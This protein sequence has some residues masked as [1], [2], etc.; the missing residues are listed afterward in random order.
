MRLVAKRTVYHLGPE[1]AAVKKEL[2]RRRRRDEAN[3]ASGKSRRELLKEQVEQSGRELYPDPPTVDL[4]LEI[5]NRSQHPVELWSSGDPV[6]LDLEMRGP[7]VITIN[8]GHF[9]TMEFRIPQ[10]TK[11]DPGEVYRRPI[12]RLAHGTRGDGKWDY[13]TSPGRYTLTASFRTGIRPA[14]AGM[15]VEQDE[16]MAG[17]AVVVLVAPPITVDVTAMR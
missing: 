13:W 8:P 4:V 9:H 12:R 14:P 5:T 16:D 10:A 3:A 2:A 1:V 7:G 17:F 6:V 15:R 11:L